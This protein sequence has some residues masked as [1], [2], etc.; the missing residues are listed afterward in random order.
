MEET[1]NFTPRGSKSRNVE[2]YFYLTSNIIIFQCKW[3]FK[4]FK[5][6]P[7]IFGIVYYTFVQMKFQKEDFIFNFGQ[8]TKEWQFSKISLEKHARSF[9]V[10]AS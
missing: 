4:W 2:I 9:S 8:G 3:S 1:K 10:K 5:K 7:H 6:C